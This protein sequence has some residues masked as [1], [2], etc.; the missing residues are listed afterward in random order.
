MEHKHAMIQQRVSSGAAARC[1]QAL[2]GKTYECQL[3]QY[4]HIPPD[5]CLLTCVQFSSLSQHYAHG[6]EALQQHV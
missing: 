5:T 3:L 2:S 6:Y 4:Q 1:V